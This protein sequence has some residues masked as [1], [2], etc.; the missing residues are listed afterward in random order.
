M[1]GL[2]SGVGAIGLGWLR[3]HV[4]PA[5]SY[6]LVLVGVGFG[7]L[8][9]SSQFL[10]DNRYF[11]SIEALRWDI[12]DEKQV[13]R[14]CPTLG[15]IHANLAQRAAIKVLLLGEARVFE[16]PVPVVYNTCFD[17][18]PAETYLKGQ[19]LDNQKAWLRAQGVTHVLVHWF[20]IARYRSPGNYGFS[21]WPQRS[22]TRQW[23]EDGLVRS[24]NWGIDP[25]WAELLEVITDEQ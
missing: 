11:V 20:E 14:I 17:R 13:P 23:I 6:A 21:E 19:S 24:V 22:D 25:N 10:A 2:W 5:L 16:Y 3:E 12:G 9:N 7:G 18:S 15:W 8:I 4:S 1:I